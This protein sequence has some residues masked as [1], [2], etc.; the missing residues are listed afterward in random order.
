MKADLSNTNYQNDQAHI[1][2]HHWNLHILPQLAEI[3]FNNQISDSDLNLADTKLVVKDRT[4]TITQ[5]NPKDLLHRPILSM[6][7]KST[8]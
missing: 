7:L 5:S 3:I 1:F 2:E 8:S 6:T 4:Y